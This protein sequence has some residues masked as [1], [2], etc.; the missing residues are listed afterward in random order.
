V[1][2]PVLTAVVLTALTAALATTGLPAG[3]GRAGAAAAPP[4]TPTARTFGGTPTVGPLF[5][6]GSATHTCT[7]SVVDSA[8]GNLLITATHCIAGDAKGYTFVPGY[9]DGIAPY[10]SWTVTGAYASP[11]WVRRRS[12]RFDV[13]F[14]VVAPQRRQGRLRQ[15]QTVTGADR[16]GTAPAPGTR[17]TVPAYPIGRDDRPLTCTA[18]VTYRDGYPA[19]DCTPYVDGTSGAPW[20]WRSRGGWTVVGVIGGLHQG[21]CEPWTSYSAPFGSDAR[22]TY[23]AA[24]RGARTT[25]FPGPESDGCTTGL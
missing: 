6:P 24:V 21:G 20:L 23:A 11:Q 9:H 15:I 18:R 8:V 22:Q 10:G 4:G 17:V 2:R 12:P 25:T 13:A 16:M 5:P 7:A 14:L 3:A 1:R 19:F